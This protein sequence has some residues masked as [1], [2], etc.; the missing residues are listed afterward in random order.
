V[1]HSPSA[2][3][4]LIVYVCCSSDGFTVCMENVT[5]F[6]DGPL[7]L[8]AVYAFVKQTSYRYVAQLVLSL[9]QLYGDV[10]YFAIEMFDGFTH[11]PVGHPL[12]F[13]FYF[14]FLNSLWIIIP[15]AC[16]IESWK[17]IIVSQATTDFT[18]SDKSKRN[19][20]KNS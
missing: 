20:L 17:K 14:V 1:S 11:G 15:F 12:Y 8:L 13:W 7:A 2:I 19:I 5:A 9:C 6:V 16:I 10:L 4:E 3:Y 18:D